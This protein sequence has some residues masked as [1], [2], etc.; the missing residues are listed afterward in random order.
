M[1]NMN[2]SPTASRAASKSMKKKTILLHIF[3]LKHVINKTKEDKR[4]KEI[5][6]KRFFTEKFNF[7]FIKNHAEIIQI[8]SYRQSNVSLFYV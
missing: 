4:I 1:L 5:L 7:H 3:D 2:K 6:N 8:T